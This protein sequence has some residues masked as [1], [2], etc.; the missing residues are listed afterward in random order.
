M[1]FV[2]WTSTSRENNALDLVKERLSDLADRIF[3]P[4]RTISIKRG[5]EW[6][7]ERTALFPGYLFV[8]TDPE[9]IE[10]LAGK[11]RSLSGFNVVLS[12]DD[13]FLP[14]NEQETAFIEEIYGAGGSF[15][16]S[17]GIIEGEQI[18]ITSGPLM[19]LE[20][21]ITKIDRHKRRAYLELNMFGVKTKTS[22]S[23][24]IIEKNRE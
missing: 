4:Q 7:L 24:E 13:K 5:K 19:G 1:W 11:M 22:V 17:V 15:D 3:V 16:A 20:G 18:K 6:V 10:I 2:I 9:R 21:S 14:L 8:D 12:T 23:L